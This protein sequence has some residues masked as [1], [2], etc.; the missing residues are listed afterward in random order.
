MKLVNAMQKPDLPGIL[1]LQPAGLLSLPNSVEVSD[2]LSVNGSGVGGGARSIKAALGEYFER[3]HFYR[4]IISTRNGVLN[5]SLTK[6]EVDSFACALTQT[7]SKLVSA[8]EIEKHQF[9]LT[10]VMRASDFSECFIPTI[11]ISLSAYGLA[12]DNFLYPLRDTCGCS[13]HWDLNVA[14][15]G[16]VKEYLER[17]FLI[18]FWLTKQCRSLISC[19]K[20]ESLLTGRNVKY[21][22][23]ALVFSGEV[24][25]FDISDNRFPGVC[26]LVVYGQKKANHH[27]KYCAGMSYCG[28]VA[29]ALEKSLLELWQTYRFMDLFKAIESDENKVE[30]SYLRYFLSCNDYITYQEITDYVVVADEQNREGFSAFSLDVFLSVL[31]KL[32]ILGYFYSTLSSVNGVNCVFAKYISPDLFLH[33]DSSKNINLKNRYSESFESSI[34]SSRLEAMVPFP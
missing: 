6:I 33:M 1:L 2:A 11:T 31:K 3:R 5:E 9:S 19:V 12:E 10:R 22:Y 15:L 13:F 8:D 7:A 30:D 32:G 16:A 20:V 18:R 17:Q 28:E 4:E 34:L 23:D 14:F 21:L 25:I 29:E 24:S 26:L 27:V